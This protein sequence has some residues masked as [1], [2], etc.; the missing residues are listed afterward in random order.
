MSSFAFRKEERTHHPHRQRSGRSRLK[1]QMR[2]A[3]HHAALNVKEYEWY[4]HFFENVFHMT[5]ERIAG[6]APHRQLWF[7]EGIQLNE[8]PEEVSA[9]PAGN[10]CDHISLGVDIP[11]AEAA[12]RAIEA[13]CRPVPGKPAH[14][15]AL[16]DGVLIELKP[17]P[18]K[19]GESKTGDGSLSDFSRK[20][21][22]EP[23]PVLLSPGQV[24]EKYRE[25]TLSLIDSGTTITTMESCTSGLVASLITDT[26]GASAIFKGS[27][28]TYSNEAKVLQGVPSRIIEDY[29]VYSVETASA[30]AEAC[31][32][33]FG[34]DIGVGVTGSFGNVDPNNSDSVPGEVFFAVVDR[35]GARSRHCHV[36]PQPSRNAYK[37]FMAD[38][39]VDEL[40]ARRPCLVPPNMV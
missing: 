15:F 35:N 14:W 13:G 16:P 39:I 19:T 36:P 4:R 27:S 37:L 5:A 26:E 9:L 34:A 1:I 22:R 6:D 10:A 2:T 25:L 28:V 21:D 30:M 18:G 32:K 38:V 7:A 24:R 11:E 33:A 40:L 17:Y 31:R 8:T 12:A 3:I 20:S 23:S 29:G